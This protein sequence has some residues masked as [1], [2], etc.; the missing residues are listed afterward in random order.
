MKF[1]LKEIQKENFQMIGVA[2]TATT[3]ISVREKMESYDRTKVHL[4]TLK[5]KDIQKNVELFLSKTLE[6]RQKIIGLESKR[7]NVI[8]SGSIVLLEIL[9]YFQREELTISEFDNL[10]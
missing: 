4:S 1:A 3:Q 7:A 5:K 10:T 9:E 8:I 2:G 6:E